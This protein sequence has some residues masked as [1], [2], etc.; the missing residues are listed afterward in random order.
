M[1]GC[2]CNHIKNQFLWDS[3]ALVSLVLTI[4]QICH[5][6][7]NMLVPVVCQ[8]LAGRRSHVNAA[9]SDTDFC[10]KEMGP[11]LLL[12]TQPCTECNNTIIPYYIKLIWIPWYHQHTFFPDLL[13]TQNRQRLFGGFYPNEWMFSFTEP[14]WSLLLMQITFIRSRLLD[15]EVKTGIPLLSF[16]MPPLWILYRWG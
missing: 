4:I 11:C 16:G 13:P 6:L 14:H 15:S 9:T 3:T 10:L 8:N 1:A 2:L 12:F 5:Q 7:H